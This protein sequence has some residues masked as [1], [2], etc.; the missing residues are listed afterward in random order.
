MHSLRDAPHVVDLRNIG[1]VAG[2][3]L[4]PRPDA[5]GARGFE[6]FLKCFE[7][8]LLVRVTADTIA[9]SP[10]LIVQESQIDRM[11]EVVRS[12]LKTV[13]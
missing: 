3:E 9:L 5:P 13:A 8:G 7:A 10:P 6:V 12:A 1:L 11:F 2:I 4:A